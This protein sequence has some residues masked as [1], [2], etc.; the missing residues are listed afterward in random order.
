MD[1]HMANKAFN[2][3]TNGDTDRNTAGM[4]CNFISKINVFLRTNLD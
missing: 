1:C 3:F 2:N 4:E